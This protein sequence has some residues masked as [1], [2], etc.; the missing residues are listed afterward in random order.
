MDVKMTD[1]NAEQS[2]LEQFHSIVD[3]TDTINPTMK[4]SPKEDSEDIPFK[5]MDAIIIG[6][7]SIKTG[8]Y[9]TKGFLDLQEKSDKENIFGV[10]LKFVFNS[11]VRKSFRTKRY[12]WNIYYDKKRNRSCYGNT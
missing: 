6:F 2:Q 11:I 1:G 5:E 10:F 4:L 9:G 7:K 8:S 12:I 3:T